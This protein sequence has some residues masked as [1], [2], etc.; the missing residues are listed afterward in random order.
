VLGIL[1]LYYGLQDRSLTIPVKS[2]Q[3]FAQIDGELKALRDALDRLGSDVHVVERE[4]KRQFDL[5]RA[6]DVAGN[7]DFPRLFKRYVELAS[8]PLLF[9]DLRQETTSEMSDK[10]K[11]AEAFDLLRELKD[12]VVRLVRSLSRYGT[13][14]T[15]RVNVDWADYQGRAMAILRIVAT[16]RLA[17]NDSDEKRPLA[18]LAALTGKARDTQIE[19]YVALAREGGHLLDLALEAY[20]AT[21]EQLENY[22]EQH[23]LDLFQA[24]GTRFLTARMRASGVILR[25]QTAR[26][27]A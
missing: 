12:V 18:V 3:L 7:T 23:L 2:Q 1:A 9:L 21:K 24:Q 6:T 25:D 8:N 10:E 14:A 4:A 22:D 11:V 26:V 20:R 19:P 13:I 5:G 27:W 17:E 15:M 16:E